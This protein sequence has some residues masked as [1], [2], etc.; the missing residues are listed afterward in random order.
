MWWEQ[1]KS[2]TTTTSSTRWASAASPAAG[3]SE[4]SPLRLGLRCGV[5]DRDE[6]I[7]GAAVLAPSNFLP[8]VLVDPFRDVCCAGVVGR[9]RLTA[10]AIRFDASQDERVCYC[11]RML[12]T[13][14]YRGPHP[15]SSA[16]Q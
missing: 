2:T 12:R 10:S 16:L 7:D 8:S 1:I 13:D 9:R 4:R 14:R 3:G 5:P 15:S 6:R 11:A